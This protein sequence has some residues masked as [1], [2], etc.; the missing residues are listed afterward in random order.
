MNSQNKLKDSIENMMEI[1][2]QR[3]IELQE[4][5]DKLEIR[6]EKV[7]DILKELDG[8][9]NVKL[10]V[11]NRIFYTHQDIL[12]KKEDSYFH[13]FFNPKFKQENE[14]GE[15]IIARDGDVFAYVLEYLTYDE[16]LSEIKDVGM[17]KKLIKDADYYQL[18]ELKNIAEKMMENISN[19]QIGGNNSLAK[20]QSSSGQNQG[21]WNWNH[22][23][24]KPNEGF[25]KLENG[26]TVRVLQKGTYMV[27]IRATGS[28]YGNSD[29]IELYI[30][31]QNGI[32]RCVNSDANGY[33][34]SWEINEIFNFEEN[35]TLQVYNSFS[36]PV[37]NNYMNQF[38]IV[39]LA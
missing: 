33:Q 28:S 8:K 11:G 29:Y 24:I 5:Q 31:G 23:I 3:E 18:K 10:L 27:L 4:W 34:I 16:L 13:G 30:N 26:N 15:Y 37:N 25:Y 1:V 12:T 38:S 19:K 7:N 2:K 32:S 39:K 21:Y 35:T 36:G 20:W 22:E 14:N 6:E 9:K 17:L